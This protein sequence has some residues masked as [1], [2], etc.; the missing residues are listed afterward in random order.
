M[1]FTM[2]GVFHTLVYVYLAV[3]TAYTL[4]FYPL[5]DTLE[6]TLW[7]NAACRLPSLLLL[8]SW[9]WAAAVYASER[10]DFNLKAITSGAVLPSSKLISVNRTLTMVFF[11]VHLSDI[12]L[13]DQEDNSLI[14]FDIHMFL[15]LLVLFFFLNPFDT[16][17]S[18]S[19]LSLLGTLS[20][21]FFS[22]ASDRS[23]TFFHVLVA[24]IMTS[25]SKMLADCQ[26]MICLSVGL[27]MGGL[28][29]AS[30]MLSDDSKLYCYDNILTPLVISFPFLIR[31]VQSCV[32]LQKSAQKRS[33]ALMAIIKY[34]TSIIYIVLSA[35]KRHYH[36]AY[37]QKLWIVV[38][39]FNSSYSFLWD[40]R[41]DWGMVVR[42][43]HPT[44][45]TYLG[46]LFW[47]KYKWHLD[48]PIDV[49]AV[50]LNFV[51]RIVWSLKLSMPRQF[52]GEF[53]VF[54]F[55]VLEILRRGMWV[56]LRIR[57]ENHKLDKVKLGEDTDVETGERHRSSLQ[58][59]VL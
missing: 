21:L 39:M 16:F 27:A 4:L 3:G 24:D 53:G 31:L 54:V 8:L 37:F 49:V 19:R 17:H 11:A 34:V 12:I 10:F 46:L 33:Y 22:T 42:R 55:E 51:G 23:Q 7:E 28:D 36:D 58:H 15:V 5:W 47:R 48:D 44:G 1:K 14:R 43:E 30:F 45:K 20:D 57:H 9:T 59:A 18:E 38:I 56:F 40:I 29:S 13:T 25:L 2:S 52:G 26:V 6:E 50:F 41:H 32:M 35:L